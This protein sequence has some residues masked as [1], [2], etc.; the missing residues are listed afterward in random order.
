LLRSARRWRRARRGAERRQEPS[1]AHVQQLRGS[2]QLGD[3]FSVIE[4][5]FE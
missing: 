5:V 1:G 2:N 4:A 3:D